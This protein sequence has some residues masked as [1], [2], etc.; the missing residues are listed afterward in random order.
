MK[1]T[2]NNSWINRVY[3]LK[4]ID[5]CKVRLTEELIRKNVNLFMNEIKSNLT[6]ESHIL[7]FLR[8]QYSS[9]GIATI[10]KLHKFM[11]NEKGINDYINSIVD[12]LN[13]KDD[14][15]KT[16]LIRKIVFTY[17]INSGEVDDNLK[18]IIPNRILNEKNDFLTY[19]K[20]KLP[21]AFNPLDYEDVV[22]L[23]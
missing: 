8:L 9:S 13:F 4:T 10:G 22:K 3:N 11:L 1:N 14:D 5:D 18:T 15:Y 17:A 23:N 12:I 19:Y 21:I 2:K 7:I 16:E 6:E 20:Y